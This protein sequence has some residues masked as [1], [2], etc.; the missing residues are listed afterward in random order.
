MTPTLSVWLD[1]CRVIAAFAVYIGHSVTLRV[2]PSALSTTWHRSADDAVIAFFVLSGVV[3]AHTTRDRHA[4][5]GHYALARLSRVYSVAVPAVLF[6]LAVDLVG[7]SLTTGHPMYSPDWQY[8]RLW[9]FLPFHWLFL[10]ETWFGSIQPFTMAPYWS[11]GY[12]VWYYLLFGV[13]MFMKGRARWIGLA[14]VLIFVGPR[15]LLLLPVWWSGVWL[16]GRLDRLQ[17]TAGYAR[18]VMALSVLAYVAFFN[19]GGREATDRASRALYAL[20]DRIGP[21]PFF[22]GQGIHVLSDYV[23]GLLFAA[24][25]VGCSRC[26]CGFSEAATRR[27]RALAGYTFTFY[28]IHFSL[29]L[30]ANAM[31][32]DQ[33]GWVTYFG[34]TALVFLCTFLLAQ[35]GERRKAWYAGL[36]MRLWE[37]LV[38]LRRRIL[39]PGS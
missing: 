15:I 26:E 37:T 23:V 38:S 10:G 22:P 24:F 3:I 39:S 8:P 29:L 12:E 4:S 6:V 36:F 35:V 7:M 27:I 31:G 5:A 9:L 20:W 17:L 1:L 21:S 34:V 25:I 33:P 14:I 11:L 28:L 16:Y 32:V 18:A 2:A 19:W 30:F 13:F